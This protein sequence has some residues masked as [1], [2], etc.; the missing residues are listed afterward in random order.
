MSVGYETGERT[1]EV[2]WPSQLLLA[3]I[4]ITLLA[5]PVSYAQKGLGDRVG[6]TR[7]GL[8]PS[9][10][11][12]SVT[13]TSVETHPC[14]KTVGYAVLGTHLVAEGCDGKPYNIHLGPADAVAPIAKRLV[15]GTRLDVIAFRT[16]RMPEDQFVARTLLLEGGKKIELRDSTLRPFWADGSHVGARGNPGFPG[17]GKGRGLRFQSRQ[18]WP[19]RFHCW[20]GSYRGFGR[21]PFRKPELP[22]SPSNTAAK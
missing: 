20:Q 21:R 10:T 12:L 11:R 8:T 16:S 4:G 14:E 17:R 19:R 2:P 6:V 13:V 3:V 9:L 1:D 5:S 7:Q 22:A 15:P 18:H